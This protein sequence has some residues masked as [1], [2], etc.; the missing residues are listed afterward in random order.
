V[1]FCRRLGIDAPA[2]LRPV[3]FRRFAIQAQK[4]GRSGHSERPVPSMLIRL[5]RLAENDR[6]VPDRVEKMVENQ[7]VGN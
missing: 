6:A 2:D 7:V 4:T 3:E 5:Q 1:D